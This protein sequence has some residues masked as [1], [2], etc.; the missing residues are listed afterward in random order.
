MRAEVQL[1]VDCTF[2]GAFHLTL[3]QPAPQPGAA[4]LRK[5]NAPD[6]IFVDCTFFGAF[7]LTLFAWPFNQVQRT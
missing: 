5:C 2:F 3:E 4:H 7:H 1:F 6:F